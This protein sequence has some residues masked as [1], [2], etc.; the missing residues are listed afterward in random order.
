MTNPSA[1]TPGPIVGV[2]LDAVGPH[3]ATRR[4]VDLALVAER[5]GIDF[6]SLDDTLDPRSPE[7]RPVRLDALL[8]LAHVAAATTSTIGL[9]ATVT[10]T[11]TE[12]FHVSKNIATLDLVSGGRAGWQ[13]SVSTTDGGGRS[14]RPPT[15][16]RR[17]TT[18][19]P[20]PT[21]WSRSCADCGT[22]GRTTLS[23][24]I[25]RPVATSIA[26]KVHYVDFEGRFFD[27]RGPSITP[28]PPQGQPIVAVEADDP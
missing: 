18:C 21:T 2:A 3:Q 12:P 19:T 23:S 15:D 8:A 22:A 16:A 10:V 25:D 6:V 7:G 5:G 24:A 20:R 26:T 28:R 13:V 17:S 27:V 9:L 4:L 14:V 11:H 1:S